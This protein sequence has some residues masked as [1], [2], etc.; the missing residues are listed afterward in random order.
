MRS[1]GNATPLTVAEHR[2]L[3]YELRKNRVRLRELCGLIMEVYG[4]NTRAYYS[5][6]KAAETLEQLCADMQTQA[7]RDHPGFPTDNLYT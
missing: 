7:M 5:F 1:T 2:E 6:Q 4:P 3:G